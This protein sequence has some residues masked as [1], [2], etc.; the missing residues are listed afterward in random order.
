MSAETFST[1]SD[2]LRSVIRRTMEQPPLHVPLRFDAFGGIPFAT[3]N[4]AS[5]LSP[6]VRD[7]LTPQSVVRVVGFDGF[8]LTKK[9]Y[10]WREELAKWLGKGASVRYLLQEPLPETPAAVSEVR[11]MAGGAGRLE[12][13]DAFEDGPSGL[14][15]H[16]STFHFVIVEN[17]DLLWVEGCHPR[18]ATQAT[19]CRFFDEKLAPAIPAY[20]MLRAQFDRVFEQES[21]VLADT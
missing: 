5:D 12:I 15:H 10:P 11:Q 17:P 14:V 1:W 3:A 4:I 2:Y 19:D 20:P 9:D 7:K 16:W 6:L 18:G 21:V 13:R 8:S